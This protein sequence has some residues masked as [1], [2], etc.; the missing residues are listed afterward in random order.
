MMKLQ[1]K[2]FSYCVFQSSFGHL[3]LRSLLTKHCAEISDE[4]PV[5]A[6]F[7]SIGSLGASPATW[8]TGEFLETLS[9]QS[10]GSSRKPHLNLVNHSFVVFL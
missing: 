3:K 10:R 9:S 5:I 8:L 7:S 6:Q 4:W 1:K 2:V